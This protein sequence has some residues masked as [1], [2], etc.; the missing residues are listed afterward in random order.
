MAIKTAT[1][2]VAMLKKVATEYKTLYVMGCFGAPMTAS[3]NERYCQNHS[4]NRQTVRQ[5][6]I[7]SATSDT[8]GFDCVCLI[9]GILWG[10]N[11]NKNHVYGGAAYTSNGVPD[12]GTEQIIAQCTDVSTDFSKLQIGEL[13]WMQGHVGV[14]IGGGKCVECTPAWKN[15]VQITDVLNVRSGTGH[16]W[17]KHDKLPYVTYNGTDVDTPAAGTASKVEEKPKLKTLPTLMYGDR[18]SMVTVLQNLLIY[19]GYDVGPDGADGDYGGKTKA[20]VTKLQSDNNLKP[21]DGI[22]GPATWPLVTKVS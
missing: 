18:G 10:W 5:V 15:C 9:K 21:A 13:L 14:Y 16:R 22:C 4:Y 6:M 1:E 20:A 8:F 19:N 7:K 17:T 3:N 11:G 12:I 2:L